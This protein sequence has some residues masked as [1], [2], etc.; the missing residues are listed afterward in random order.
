[1]ACSDATQDKF[2]QLY[3]TSDKINFSATVL[4]LVKLTQ[5][6]L[7]LFNILSID[8]LD[9][10]LCD[11]TEQ[12]I[13]EWWNT[14][15]TRF[16]DVEPSDGILGPTTVAGIIGMTLGVRYR[17]L[18]MR[19]EAPKDMM[20][21]EHFKEAI[22]HFQKGVKLERTRVLD[23]PTLDKLYNLTVWKATAERRLPGHKTLRTTVHD[24]SNRTMVNAADIETC[25]IEEFIQHVHGERL[26]YMWQGKG[27]RPSTGSVTG[28]TPSASF[29]DLKEASVSTRQKMLRGV[30]TGAK[31]VG[32]MVIRGPE[33]ML[34]RVSTRGAQRRGR[35]RDRE[36]GDEMYMGDIG[37]PLS[38][39][40]TRESEWGKLTPQTSSRRTR[41]CLCRG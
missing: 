15:G 18:S 7:H 28:L 11:V 39:V 16:Y 31:G 27:R 33:H 6:C 1:M 2:H 19:V 20:D 5:S 32:K 22:G 38:T 10:L 8:Y 26:K 41:H 24:L 36:I 40:T 17:L 9:G 23:K 34:E 35:E 21:I 12:S 4:D 37:E 3:R 13:I 29:S 14:Y 25:D 30:K